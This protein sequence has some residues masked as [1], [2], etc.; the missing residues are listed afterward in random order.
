VAVLDRLG[1]EPAVHLT[2]LDGQPLG[3]LDVVGGQISEGGAI[4]GLF[5]DAD[6][7][8]VETGHDDLVRVGSAQGQPTGLQETIP[9]RP[10]RDGRLYLKTGV[11]DKAAGRIFVQA[12][13]R[14]KK[15]AW[16][17]ALNLGRP[18]LHILLLDSDLAGNVYVAAEV[19]QED[20][21][22]HEMRDLATIVI[23]LEGTAG[24]LDAVLELPPTTVDPAETFRPLVLG[25]DGTL[26]QLLAS[27]S[28]IT[29]TA[30]HM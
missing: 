28:G 26:Y 30:Y 5:A 1:L 18:L 23:R 10:S 19:G 8:Y 17:S 12:H 16:E 13:D 27:P 14:Q 29:V 20:P 25:D 4:T 6:G 11:I 2:D 9:G 15:L 21:A 24:Q 7:I 22:T 3:K